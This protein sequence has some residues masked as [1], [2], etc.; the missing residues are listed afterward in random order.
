MARPKPGNRLHLSTLVL[1]TLGTFDLV[2][3]LMWLD[4]GY[5]E[6]N[7]LFEYF[8]L[9]GAMSL[10][11]AKIG[12]LVGPIMLLEIARRYRPRTA[13]LGTWVAAGAYAYLYVGHLLSLRS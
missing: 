13:E 1:V 5:A 12:F 3:T 6:G 7:P 9:R 4:A 10:T 2:T 8:A 11:I